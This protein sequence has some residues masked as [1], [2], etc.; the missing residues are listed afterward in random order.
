MGVTPRDRGMLRRCHG[1]KPVTGVPRDTPVTG[2][3][4]LEFSALQIFGVFENVFRNDME[5]PV[6]LGD[7]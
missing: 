1:P 7:G 2:R 4:V 6:V 5:F 3:D